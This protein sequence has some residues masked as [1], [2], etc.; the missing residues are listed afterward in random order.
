MLVWPE[1][2]LLATSSAGKAEEFATLLD[3]YGMKSLVKTYRDFD[4]AA[5]DETGTTF[6]ENVMIKA[7]AGLAATGLPTLADDSGLCVNAL[8]GAPGVYSADWAEQP[9][10]TRDFAAAMRR[11]D[12]ELGHGPRSAYF[13]CTLVLLRDDGICHMAEGRVTGR[14]LPAD[15]PMGDAGHGYDPWFVP[16]GY[17]L[18]FAALG[19]DV[20][21]TLSHRARAFQALAELSRG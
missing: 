16:D 6:E 19:L 20:K 13:T 4:L 18:P 14:L 1:T 10:G 8:N 11:I 17:E 2:F 9:D 3:R 21:N 5:P 12:A 15:Q 7:R